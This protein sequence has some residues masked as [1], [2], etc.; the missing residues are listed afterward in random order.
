MLA[1]TGY[2]PDQT[3]L[4]PNLPVRYA[5]AAADGEPPP[6]GPYR[7]YQVPIIDITTL[8]ELDLGPLPAADRY[9]PPTAAS[10]PAPRARPAADGPS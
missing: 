7:T 1:G 4:L 5:A 6:L 10:G 3:A 2:V 9:R 8:A